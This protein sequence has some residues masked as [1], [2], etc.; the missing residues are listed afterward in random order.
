MRFEFNLIRGK[1]PFADMC[2]EKAITLVGRFLRR[3][4]KDG[5]DLE[6]RDGMALAATLGGMAS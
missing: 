1:N 6:A 3:A 4:V 5:N 2:A